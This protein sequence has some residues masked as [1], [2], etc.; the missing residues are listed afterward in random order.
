M[1][2]VG[3]LRQRLAVARRPSVGCVE[4]RR[5]G[6]GVGL[7]VAALTPCKMAVTG[8]GWP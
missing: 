6:E 4:A 7:G 1:S 5:P 2:T 3:L 8:T